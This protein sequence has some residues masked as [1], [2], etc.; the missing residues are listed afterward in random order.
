MSCFKESCTIALIVCRIKSKVH[1][2]KY[3]IISDLH[4]RFT[5]LP[6]VNSKLIQHTEQQLC[7]G[8]IRMGM[9]KATN[10]STADLI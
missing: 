2:C 8:F 3:Y 5:H 10:P 4:N 9:L 7:Y 1:F 6:N